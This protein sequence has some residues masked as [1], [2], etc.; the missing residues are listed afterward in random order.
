MAT[1]IVFGST[2]AI[3]VGHIVSKSKKL[4]SAMMLC[5]TASMFFF[6]VFVG[7][8]MLEN[9]IFLMIATAF[10]GFATTSLMP[11]YIE[12]G[13]EISFPVNEA[14][15]AGMFGVAGQLFGVASVRKIWFTYNR[16][17]W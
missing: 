15:S 7:V 9:Q 4:R 12:F 14:A 6:L 17:K 3:T 10:F 8:M 16:L 1:A 11:L 13:I 2:G 5:M